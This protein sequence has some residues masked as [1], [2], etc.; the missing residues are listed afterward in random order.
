M[1]ILGH[2]GASNRV[3][4]STGQALDSTVQ[5][6]CDTSAFSLPGVSRG[7][8]S[9]VEFLPKLQIPIRVGQLQRVKEKTLSLT[10]PHPD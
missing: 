8:V 7:S 10:A 5:T 6:L 2:L 4:K 9:P 1:A 3:E